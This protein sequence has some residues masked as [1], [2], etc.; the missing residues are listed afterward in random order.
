M[1]KSLVILTVLLMLLLVAGFVFAERQTCGKCNGSGIVC[2]W[3][4]ASVSTTSGYH[5]GKSNAGITCYICDGKRYVEIDV[6][7]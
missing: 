2:Q 7:K 1:K 4:G 6:C 5:C 3:C